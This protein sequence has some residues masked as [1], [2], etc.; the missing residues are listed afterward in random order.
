MIYFQLLWT[1]VQVGLF[2]IGG[3]YA[4]IPVIQSHVVE[5][6]QWL[7]LSDFTDLVTIAEMT[8]GPI[9]INAATFVGMRIGGVAGALVATLGAILPALIIVSAL[10]V[11]YNKFGNLKSVQI[12]LHWLKPAIVALIASAALSIFINAVWGEQGFSTDA[13]RIDLGALIIFVTAFVVLRKCKKC[14]PVIV[15]LGA[16]AF[17]LVIQYLL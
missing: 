3:G 4:A 5:G 12:V 10:A 11:L 15:M 17:N 13:T 1:F 7:T 9:T 6:Y 8:P 2:S 16:G 14:S